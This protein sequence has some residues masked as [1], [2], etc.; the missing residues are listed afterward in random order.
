MADF[1][2]LAGVTSYGDP[3]FSDQLEKNLVSFFQWG[4]LGVGAFAN[5][6]LASSGAY[7]GNYSN[8]RLGDFDSTN[9]NYSKGQVWEGIRHDW[10]WESGVEYTT[11]PI[12]ISGVYVNGSFKPTSGVG[13]YAHHINYPLGRVIFDSP[14]SATARVAVEHSYR[15]VHVTSSDTMWWRNIQFNSLRADDF[16]IA[17]YGSGAWSILAEN[18]IQLPAMVVEVLPRLT[19]Y[20]YEMGNQVKTTLKDVFFHI[21]TEDTFNRKQ[22]FD[23]ITYQQD[24]TIIGFDL[25]AIYNSGVTPLN[26]EGTPVPGFLTYPQLVKPVEDGGFARR[27]IIFKTVNGEAQHSKLPFYYTIARGTFEVKTPY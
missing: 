24:K 8:L 6:R 16:Q 23:I 18:S 3:L 20:G 12:Q 22:L 10:V 19:Q 7:G 21:L 9:S 26:S 11:Q 15:Y 14:I 4:L 25:T 5:V 13:P 17:Q 1:T 2:N 27:K